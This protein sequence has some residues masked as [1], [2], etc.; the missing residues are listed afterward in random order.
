MAFVVLGLNNRLFSL[1]Y[2]SHYNS[3]CASFS[4]AKKPT[5]PYWSQHPII[6]SRLSTRGGNYNR[7]LKPL[8]LKKEQK[9]KTATLHMD[10][11]KLCLHFFFFSVSSALSHCLLRSSEIPEQQD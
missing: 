6:P 9:Q 11:Q 7:Y 5:K 10:L 3:S 4:L 1:V 8:L 2:F